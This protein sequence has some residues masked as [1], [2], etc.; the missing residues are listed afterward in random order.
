PSDLRRWTASWHPFTPT[1]SGAS[2]L[3]AVMRPS[4]GAR[5]KL[6]DIWVA[7]LW[8]A[9]TSAGYGRASRGKVGRSSGGR[10]HA[11]SPGG[12]SLVNRDRKQKRGRR[13]EEHTYELQSRENLV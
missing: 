13:S 7:R 4:S 11:E 9:T 3:A 10:P 1:W 6:R 2:P 12:S 5:S 8:S